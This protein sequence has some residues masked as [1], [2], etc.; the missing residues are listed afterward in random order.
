M[1]LK[2]ECLNLRVY[3]KSLK[4]FLL[5]NSISIASLNFDVFINYYLPHDRFAYIHDISAYRQY[6]STRK[7]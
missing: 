6:I 4:R 5:L 1:Y 7:I 2:F 3:E